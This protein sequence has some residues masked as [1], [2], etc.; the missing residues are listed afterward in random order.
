MMVNDFVNS[1]NMNNFDIQELEN[2]LLFV[3]K[4]KIILPESKI[5]MDKSKFTSSYE[6]SAEF[7][8]KCEKTASGILLAK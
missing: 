4:K 7:D 2:S 3:T 6:Y 8:S 1:I 5:I